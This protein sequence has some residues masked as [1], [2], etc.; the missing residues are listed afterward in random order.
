M[1][2]PEYIQALVEIIMP[3]VLVSPYI[4]LDSDR[5]VYFIPILASHPPPRSHFEPPSAWLGSCRQG[6]CRLDCGTDI[7]CLDCKDISL[8]VAW[9]VW[10]TYVALAGLAAGH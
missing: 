8:Q 4:Y 2:D 6:A 3:E 7:Y 9:Q 10:R 5:S 1:K